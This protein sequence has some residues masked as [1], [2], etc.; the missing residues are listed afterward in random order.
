MTFTLNQHYQAP[1]LLHWQGRT[2]SHD[3][4]RMHQAIQIIDLNCQFLEDRSNKGLVLI[5]FSCD[6][7]VK[8]NLG[9]IGASSAPSALRTQ[10]AKLPY[11]GELALYDVGNIQCINGDLESAQAALAHLVQHCHELGH[12]T[13]VLGGGA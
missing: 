1:T 2:G 13:L 7:G 12:K 11:L 3:A 6:E 5:G 9:R 10:L 4:K 8:R